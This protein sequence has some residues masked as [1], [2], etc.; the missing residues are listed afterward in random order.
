MSVS[1]TPAA[2]RRFEEIVARY[3]KRDAALLPV[4]W[5]AQEE[6]GH[7]SLEVRE[8][9]A[10]KIGVSLARVES[11][12]SFYTLYTMKKAG[13]HHIQVCRNIS[14]TLRGSDELLS[15]LGRELNVAPG[16]VTSDGALSYSAVECLAAC[17]GAPAIKVDGDYY[18]NTSPSDLKRLV[19]RLRGSGGEDR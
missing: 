13:K 9:V 6:F 11:V 19:A 16:E 1:F 12:V 15:C 8:L 4:L 3:P 17:G 7:L 2:E 5:L 14:C 18:E 10:E